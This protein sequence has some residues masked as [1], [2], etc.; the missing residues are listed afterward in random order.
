MSPLIVM[1]ALA[2]FF[3][4]DQ[5]NGWDSYPKW[6]RSVRYSKFGEVLLVVSGFVLVFM[7]LTQGGLDAY[8]DSSF[9]N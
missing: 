9:W 2:A 1:L 8:W 5:Q 4:T 7:V 3:M 6:V